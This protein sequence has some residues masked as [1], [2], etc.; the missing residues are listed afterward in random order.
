MGLTTAESLHKR[1]RHAIFWRY[2]RLRVIH[3]AAYDGHRAAS[4]AAQ[5][6][7]DIGHAGVNSLSGRLRGAGDD[8]H[9]FLCA[10]NDLH[11]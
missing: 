10:A 1:K 7:Q 5:R 2:F 6:V 11:T 9:F 3:P 8:N 4:E